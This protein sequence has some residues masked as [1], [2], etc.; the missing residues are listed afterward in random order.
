MSDYKE[1]IPALTSN[2]DQGFVIT[3]SSWLKNQYNHQGFTIFDRLIVINN[4]W[5]SLSDSNQYVKI[6]F[7][8]VNSASKLILTGFWSTYISSVYVND[9]HIAY[10]LDDITYTDICTIRTE[11]IQNKEYPFTFNTIT[12]KYIKIYKN[13]G[14]YGTLGAFQIYGS[15]SDYL[16]STDDYYYSI[17]ESNDLLQFPKISN[18]IDNLKSNNKLMARSTMLK[19][20]NF[21]TLMNKKFKILRIE[22]Q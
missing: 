9:W 4:G 15:V 22:Q 3:V 10:S 18:S 19:Q 1:L 21:Y 2:N 14:G 8:K 20:T 17:S 5:H 12:F 6:A 16:L 11:Q 13:T 7:P